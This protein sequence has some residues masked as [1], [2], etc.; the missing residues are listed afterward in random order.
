MNQRR[1]W[2]AG[3]VAVALLATAVFG[4]LL[5]LERSDDD[6]CGVARAMIEYNRDFDQQVDAATSMSGT[7]R[8]SR[9]A[10]YQAWADRLGEL[11]DSIE[12]PNLIPPARRVAE[13]ADQVAVVAPQALTTD[14]TAEESPPQW[15]LDLANLNEE[16]VGELVTLDEA[17][18]A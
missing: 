13:L 1:W 9:A 11:A 5:V 18:P 14:L 3:S 17:C 15:L 8:G 4:A 7:D 16:F 6:D 10:D 12:D 2:F